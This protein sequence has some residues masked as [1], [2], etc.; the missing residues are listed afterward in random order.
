MKK[1]FVIIAISFSVIAVSLYFTFRPNVMT[2][3][4]TLLPA[5]IELIS[6]LTS[7]PS[8][9]NSSASNTSASSRV[10]DTELR[11]YQINHHYYALSQQQVNMVNQALEAFDH[12]LATCKSVTRLPSER[13]NQLRLNIE[14][15]ERIVTYQ[16]SQSDDQHHWLETTNM[17]KETVMSSPRARHYRCPDN[18]AIFQLLHALPGANIE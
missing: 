13:H 18:P 1:T 15:N 8:A 3:T 10:I 5:Q 14:N 11:S 2:L 6:P 16:F 12:F 4:N 7:S 9:S 17:V